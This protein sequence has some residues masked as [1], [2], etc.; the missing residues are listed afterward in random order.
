M[1]MSLVSVAA[2]GISS[3]LD[4]SFSWASALE[5]W[6]S[7]EK[8]VNSLSAAAAVLLFSANEEDL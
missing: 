5:V 1:I 6:C 8:S 4:C 3:K 2:L 7:A